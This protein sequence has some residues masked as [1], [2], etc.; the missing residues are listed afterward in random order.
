MLTLFYY[1]SHHA[2]NTMGFIH[3]NRSFTALRVTEVVHFV[4][5]ASTYIC[6]VLPRKRW[7]AAILKEIQKALS[8]LPINQ[9]EP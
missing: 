4:W 8:I 9:G 6:L 3:S 2:L 7:V 5:F 1:Y